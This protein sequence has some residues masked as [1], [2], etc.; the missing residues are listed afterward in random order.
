MKEPGSYLLR[1]CIGWHFRLLP[2]AGPRRGA[3][4]HEK[5]A[6][7]EGFGLKINK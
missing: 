1:A 7:T 4:E 6:K 5:E 2:A 3:L